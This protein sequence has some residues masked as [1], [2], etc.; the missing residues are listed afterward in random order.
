MRVIHVATVE[1]TSMFKNS[2][3]ADLTGLVYRFSNG[4]RVGEDDLDP[5]AQNKRVF[6][7]EV[8]GYV[9]LKNCERVEA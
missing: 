6:D 1:H 4:S 8:G 5:L 3:A 9:S 2:I 7:T